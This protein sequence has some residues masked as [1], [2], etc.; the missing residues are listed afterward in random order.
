MKNIKP[1]GIYQDN[2]L[3][4]TQ[5]KPINKQS[6]PGQLFLIWYIELPYNIINNQKHTS[7]NK[8]QKMEHTSFHKNIPVET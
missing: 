7:N 4:F 5:S 1:G 6:P 2:H 3:K 8:F